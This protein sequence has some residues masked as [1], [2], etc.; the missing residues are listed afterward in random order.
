[1]LTCFHTNF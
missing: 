1:L